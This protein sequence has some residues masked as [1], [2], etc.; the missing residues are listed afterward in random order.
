M[1]RISDTLWGEENGQENAAPGVLDLVSDISHRVDGH[2]EALGKLEDQMGTLESRVDTPQAEDT[3]TNHSPYPRP[4][5]LPPD[6]LSSLQNRLTKLEGRTQTIQDGMDNMVDDD[7]FDSTIRDMVASLDKKVGDGIAHA[8]SYVKEETARFDEMCR[9]MSHVMATTEFDLKSLKEQVDKI[10]SDY[11]RLAREQKDLSQR[12]ETAN[13]TPTLGGL[14][15]SLAD[16]TKTFGDRLTRQ[17]ISCSTVL[18]NLDSKVKVIGGQYDSLVG[19]F[20][21]FETRYQNI[22]T[23][24][25]H[26]QIVNHVQRQYDSVSRAELVAWGQRLKNTS[27]SVDEMHNQ[28]NDLRN[29]TSTIAT[30]NKITI[31][32]MQGSIESLEKI[33]ASAEGKTVDG[34]ATGNPASDPDEHISSLQYFLER[35]EDNMQKLSGLVKALYEDKGWAMPDMSRLSKI[36]TTSDQ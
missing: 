36:P 10:A 4:A 34:N 9:N 28:I 18:S 30:L 24:N 5:Q 32:K 15:E 8:S 35:L 7:Y 25:L 6:S 14:R 16:L 3:G 29:L 12:N 26:R 23:E 31:P 1:E 21:A 19:A 20:R 27:T 22:T 17:E 2:N 13:G 33:S 11:E